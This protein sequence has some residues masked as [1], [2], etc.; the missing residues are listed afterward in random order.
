M[1]PK[2]HQPPPPLP[3]KKWKAPNLIIKYDFLCEF[4]FVEMLFT[5]I[6]RCPKELRLNMAFNKTSAFY[7]HWITNCKF[8]LNVKL[9]SKNLF[10]NSCIS[11]SIIFLCNIFSVLKTVFLVILALGLIKLICDNPLDLSYQEKI[12][13]S[14]LNFMLIAFSCLSSL[15]FKTMK[16]FSTIFVFNTVDSFNELKVMKI[17]MKLTEIC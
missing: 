9:F 4:Y 16:L 8:T 13:A 17:I 14:N 15:N 11:L 2:S 12:L 5:G 7:H 6:M 1:L 10:I 3:Y